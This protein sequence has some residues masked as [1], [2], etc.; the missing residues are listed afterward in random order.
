V[1][2]RAAVKDEYRVMCTAVDAGEAGNQKESDTF[3]GISI[4]SVRAVSASQQIA[5]RGDDM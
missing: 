5:S 1:K 2:A 3:W 4:H